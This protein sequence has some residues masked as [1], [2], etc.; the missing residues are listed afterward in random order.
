MLKF[1]NKK[2]INAKAGPS[3]EYVVMMKKQI[4]NSL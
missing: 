4:K 2:N 1:N 3:Q